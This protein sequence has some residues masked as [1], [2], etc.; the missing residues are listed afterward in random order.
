MD[1]EQEP[2]YCPVCGESLEDED[3]LAQGVHHHY[4]TMEYL[5]DDIEPDFK[6]VG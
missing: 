1:K 3:E 5:G 6:G 2:V 4:M